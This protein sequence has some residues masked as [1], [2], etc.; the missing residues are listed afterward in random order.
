MQ[1]NRGFLPIKF[2]KFCI[3]WKVKCFFTTGPE[4]ATLAGLG[5]GWGRGWWRLGD[6]GE[7]LQVWGS[8]GMRSS[9]HRPQTTWSENILLW[10]NISMW[11]NISLRKNIL[12]WKNIL[13]CKIFYRTKIFHFKWV[14]MRLSC[15]IILQNWKN[16]IFYNWV[17]K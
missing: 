1:T 10:K 12:C 6:E 9:P 3:S 4:S 15:F 14:L 13:L 7:D 2:E 5:W 11:K 17:E 8:K 16:I